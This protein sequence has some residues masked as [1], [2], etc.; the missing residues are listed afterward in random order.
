MGEEVCERVFVDRIVDPAEFVLV[1]TLTLGGGTEG[2]TVETKVEDWVM[3]EPTELV[4]VDTKTLVD[5]Y[6]A[7]GLGLDDPIVEEPKEL[8]V[9]YRVGVV[10]VVDEIVKVDDVMTVDPKESVVE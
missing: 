5:V 1:N 2:V 6:G 8:G 7:E 4:V 3:T 10:N 9:E